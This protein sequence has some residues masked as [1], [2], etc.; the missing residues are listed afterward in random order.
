MDAV[1]AKQLTH[2]PC[3]DCVAPF[4]EHAPTCPMRRALE[5]RT[6]DDRAWFDAHPNAPYRFRRLHRAEVQLLRC[7]GDVASDADLSRWR[8]RVSLADAFT[9]RRAFI[10][11]R[12]DA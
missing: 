7:S 12:G 5:E 10:S 6:D 2:V 11:P 1:T 8:V 9:W 4:G 3:P